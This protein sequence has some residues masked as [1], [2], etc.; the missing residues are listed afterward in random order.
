MG[1]KLP[2][3]EEVGKSF[4]NVA[5]AMDGG[6]DLACAILGAAHIEKHL[7]VLLRKV[8]IDSPAIIKSMFG[9]GAVLE[10]SGAQNDVALILGL[11]SAETHRNIKL[12]NAIRNDF[13][14]A[15][16]ELKFDNLD[17]ANR[18]GQL[19]FYQSSPEG[20]AEAA[21]RHGRDSKFQF[22]TCIALTALCLHLTTERAKRSVGPELDQVM[23]LAIKTIWSQLPRSNNS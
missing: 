5:A 6:S 22:K 1:R 17:I 18:C 9:T 8:F 23:E 21:K 14:H 3:Q 20:R 4:D 10:N 13:A 19:T 2:T 12:I 16:E 15:M 7:G 11:I